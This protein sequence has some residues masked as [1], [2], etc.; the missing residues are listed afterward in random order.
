MAKMTV[1]YK[2]PK[3]TNFFEKH[4]FEVHIPLAKK[5]P[6]LLKYE[7]NEGPILSLTGHSDVYRV[8]NLYFESM[9]SMMSAFKSEI[10]Q[11]CAVDRRIFA[12]DEEVQIYVY[13]TKNT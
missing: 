11:E 8:A 7:I 5:L 3:D 2:T 4:Y 12:S 9:E 10:G 6:G 1:I 13:D